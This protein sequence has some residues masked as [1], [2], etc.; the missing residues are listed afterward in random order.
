MKAQQFFVKDDGAFP[1]N[2]LP[3]VL[4]PKV[5]ELP[6]LFTGLAIRRLFQ[7]NDW[8]NNW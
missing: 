1:N 4:Y 2:S 6:R 8:G 3:I 7:K 5:L